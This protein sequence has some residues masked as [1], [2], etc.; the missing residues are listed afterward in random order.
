MRQHEAASDTLLVRMSS[1]RECGRWQGYFR[2]EYQDVLAGTSAP[3]PHWHPLYLPFWGSAVKS[4]PSCSPLIWESNVLS[5]VFRP[6]STTSISAAASE[7]TLLGLDLHHSLGQSSAKMA[8]TV[9][10]VEITPQPPSNTIPSTSTPAQ[11]PQIPQISSPAP[12]FST[13]SNLPPQQPQ[14]PQQPFPQSPVPTMPPSLPFQP[15]PQPLPLP[16]PQTP[17]NNQSTTAVGSSYPPR[18]APGAPGRNY[19]NTHLAPYLRTGMTSILDV[20]SAVP[21]LI[22]PS[23]NPSAGHNIPCAGSVNT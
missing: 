12:H 15:Q 17:T 2:Q 23:S 20:K 11:P 22:P 16:Q 18:A 14:Q 3:H 6:F 5:G 4:A 19:L 9:N 7:Q 8:E 13:P 10:P 21:S 1:S